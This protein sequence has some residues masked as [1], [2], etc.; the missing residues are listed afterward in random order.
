MSDDTNNNDIGICVWITGSINETQHIEV[1]RCI[2]DFPGWTGTD[3][4]NTLTIAMTS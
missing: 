1:T 2:S 4:D 3:T